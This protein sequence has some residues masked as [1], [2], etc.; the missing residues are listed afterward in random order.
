M[1]RPAERSPLPG[2][3]VRHHRQATGSR[4]LLGIALVGYA[5]AVVGSAIAA[6][7]AGTV[8]GEIDGLAALLAGQAGFWAVLVATVVYAS[9][10]G[11]AGVEAASLR[12]RWRWTDLPI[13][14]AVGVL[15]QLVV[16]PLVCLPLRGL[17]DEDDL[18][19]PARELFDRVGGA[20][21][22]AMAVGV[23]VVAPIVEE[24]FFR[25]LLLQAMRRRWGTTV[26]M[27]GSSVVF[28]ATHFQPLQFPALAVAGGVFAGAAVRTGRLGPAVAI[29]AGFNVTTFV[30]LV[31]LG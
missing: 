22:V 28:G 8:T 15:T 4:R 20:G 5:V 9:R 11:G 17:V 14:S 25:G 3:H 10:H 1:T 13:G 31:L 18:S 21:L 26:A 6:G 7:A 30:A 12:I 16:V 27:V 24:L 2:D 19:G 23:I 29:H